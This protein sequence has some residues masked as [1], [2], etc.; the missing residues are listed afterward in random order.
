MGT[1][2]T[3]EI[4]IAETT[5]ID[6]TDIAANRDDSVL[7]VIG[8]ADAGLADKHTLLKLPIP[9]RRSLSIPDDA[10]IDSLNIDLWCIA[11]TPDIQL[12]TTSQDDRWQSDEVTFNSPYGGVK[13]QWTPAWSASSSFLQTFCSET[14]VLTKLI[15][16]QLLWTMIIM[17][18]L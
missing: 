1:T 3:A 4:T 7:E 9:T 10:I 6:G 2:T 18:V 11:G 16:L 14:N 13:A 8:K 12:F 5:W 15:T 17:V